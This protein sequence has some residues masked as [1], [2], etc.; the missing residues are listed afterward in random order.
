MNPIASSLTYL[1][2]CRVA[3]IP[4]PP[5]AWA[6]SGFSIDEL[7]DLHE[8]LARAVTVRDAACQ[9]TSSVL[10]LCYIFHDHDHDDDDDDDDDHDDHDDDA[11][12]DGDSANKTSSFLKRR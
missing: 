7:V 11:H 10:H 4:L 3:R 1:I 2:L 12:Y 6:W 5:I 9:F 8:V